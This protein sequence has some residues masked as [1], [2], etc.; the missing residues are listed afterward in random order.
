MQFFHGTNINFV[1]KR[2]I[3]FLISVSL[4]VIGILASIILKP[5]LGIDFAGGTELAIDFHKKV[6]TQDIR[7]AF[8]KSG[9]KGSEIKS[10]GEDNQFLIRVKTTTK[11]ETMVND[12]LRKSFPDYNIEVLKVDQIGAKV[13]T[14]CRFAFSCSN[15]VIHSF[16]I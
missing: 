3:F 8:E 15:I 7:N 12:I 2:K 4:I 1:G 11:A 10:F 16:Q 13:G 14:I 5:V 6:N 9:V